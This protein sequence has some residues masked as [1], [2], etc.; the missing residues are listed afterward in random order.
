MAS[1]FE[2]L[3]FRDVKARNAALGGIAALILAPLCVGLLLEAVKA[4]A[5]LL[6]TP[7]APAGV[8]PG[9]T[10]AAASA[11]LTAP[12]ARSFPYAAIVYTVVGL[13][14]A[15]LAF[16]GAYLAAEKF[17]VRR[18]WQSTGAD[19]QPSTLI[20]GIS[21]PHDKSRGELGSTPDNGQQRTEAAARAGIEDD[22]AFR[23]MLE[24]DPPLPAE[25]LQNICEGRAALPGGA[26]EA[27]T[28]WKNFSWYPIFKTIQHFSKAGDSVEKIWLVPSHETAGYAKNWLAPAIRAVLGREKFQADVTLNGEPVRYTNYPSVQSA[29]AGLINGERRDRSGLTICIDVTGGD[30]SFAAA[31]ALEALEDDVFYS[32]LS[33][34]PSGEIQVCDVVLK[35]EGDLDVAR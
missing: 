21:L 19:R 28:L 5:E 13:G 30:K 26:D 18:R 15:V 34:D 23:W 33:Q 16:A 24:D 12:P 4:F 10:D 25:N 31:A 6:N 3:K 17:F 35:T 9:A 27:P 14:L 7:A 29:I 8:T 11:T 22:L 2:R 1:L 20:F 32:Y